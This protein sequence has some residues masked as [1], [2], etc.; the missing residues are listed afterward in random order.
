MDQDRIVFH[1]CLY[2]RLLYLWQA[3]EVIHDFDV[4]EHFACRTTAAIAI[5]V[6]HEQILVQ[7]LLLEALPRAQRFAGIRHRIVCASVWTTKFLD[8]TEVCENL[9]TINALPHERVVRQPAVLA[10][11]NLEGHEVFQTCLPIQLRQCRWVVSPE[12]CSTHDSGMMAGLSVF[13]TPAER[14]ARA[15]V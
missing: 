4:L 9:C 14:S 6:C 1:E 7:F 13:G 3:W 2:A 12:D 8:G 15:A 10:P 5:P 11:A